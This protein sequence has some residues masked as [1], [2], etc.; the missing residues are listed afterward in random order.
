MKSSNN[1]T[2]IERTEFQSVREKAGR[3]IDPETAEVFWVYAQT[4]DAYGIDPDLPDELQQ[5]GREYFARAPGSEAWVWFGDLPEAAR[6]SLWE[7]HKGKLAFPARLR[8]AFDAVCTRCVAQPRKRK[9]EVMKTYWIEAD[10]YQDACEIARDN[11]ATVTVRPIVFVPGQHVR[12]EAFPAAS[13]VV[14]MVEPTQPLCV[15]R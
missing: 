10:D 2:D 13:A 5:I 6:A 1:M 7:K 8:D 4:M 3:Q 15:R 9:F 11:S 14:V 12:A